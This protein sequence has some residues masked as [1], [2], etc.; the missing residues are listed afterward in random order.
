MEDHDIRDVVRDSVL[1]RRCL[2]DITCARTP[3]EPVIVSVTAADLPA[4][5]H[6]GKRRKSDHATPQSDRRWLGGRI[7]TVCA[8]TAL[9]ST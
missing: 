2:A 5:Q 3:N 4:H 6:P 9:A 8:P 7:E 1:D